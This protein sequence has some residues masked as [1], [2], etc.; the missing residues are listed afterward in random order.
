MLRSFETLYT[1]RTNG[2]AHCVPGGTPAGAK[3]RRVPAVAA[4]T[5]APGAVSHAT[6]SYPGQHIS[7]DCDYPQIIT[8]SYAALV[9]RICAAKTA[10]RSF[11]QNMRN[12]RTVHNAASIRCPVSF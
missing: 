6:P 5:C 11:D 9:R 2:G 7:C 1:N 4:G 8:L 3:P 10:G 12:V